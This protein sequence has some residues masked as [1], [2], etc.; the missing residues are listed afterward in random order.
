VANDGSGSRFFQ[1]DAVRTLRVNEPEIEFGG[2]SLVFWLL[3]AFTSGGTGAALAM[4]YNTGFKS[5]D[6]FAFAGAMVGAAGT[7][8]GAAWLA[9]STDKKKR[10]KEQKTILDE[11]N[12]LRRHVSGLA[13]FFPA[14]NEVSGNWGRA[15][16]MFEPHAVHANLF[17][18]EVIER[19]QTLDF[20]ERQYV[21]ELD[22]TLD[23]YMAVYERDKNWVA[24]DSDAPTFYEI[25]KRLEE[26]ANSAGAF[27]AR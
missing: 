10:R 14:N 1:A 19:A 20:S 26:A 3:V 6:V 16:E 13:P 7:V 5:D 8:A 15:L 12:R 21:K 18:K 23:E 4:L 27:C 24:Q 25:I 9:D 17:F 11:I 22:R 2:H